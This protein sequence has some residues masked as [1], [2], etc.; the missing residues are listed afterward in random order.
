MEY[1]LSK[2]TGYSFDE[3]IERA[4]EEL[5]KDG[6]GILTT[7]DIKQTL[8]NKLDVDMDKYTILGAC[9]PNFA[10]Q[11]LQIENELGLLLPC[12]VIVY[13]KDGKVHVSIMNP[14]IMASV[15]GNEKMD[16][17]GKEVKKNLAGTLERI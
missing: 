9:N 6:F 13:E 8:K 15:T 7:I 17:I 11:A 16:E 10:H 4:T 12:N 3:A 14:E 5:K 2:Q 1:G